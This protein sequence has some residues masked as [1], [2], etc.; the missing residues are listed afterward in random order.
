MP[1]SLHLLLLVSSIFLTG[2]CG[3]V[4]G[5]PEI[6]PNQDELIL[7]AGE[8]L[9]LTCRAAHPVAWCT[10]HKFTTEHYEELYDKTD[11]KAFIS[12][13][14]IDA[15]NT[16]HVGYFSC[17]FNTSENR[18]NNNCDVNDPAITSLYLYVKD[19]ENL[20]VTFQNG[21]VLHTP[22]RESVVLPCRSTFPQVNMTLTKNYEPYQRTEYDP[23]SGF[24]IKQ[25]TVKKNEGHYVCNAAYHHK[26]QERILIMDVTDLTKKPNQPTV[27]VE[28]AW[29]ED[30]LEDTVV[31]YVREG[32]SVNL[33]CIYQFKEV[34][35]SM[36]LEWSDSSSNKSGTHR[37]I[38]QVSNVSQ[39]KGRYYEINNATL[40]DS[41][42]YSCQAKNHQRYSD[43]SRLNISVVATDA[44]YLT[45]TIFDRNVTELVEENHPVQWEILFI[46]HPE[47]VFQ[48]KK[49]GKLLLD[50][51]MKTSREQFRNYEMKVTVEEA[52]LSLFLHHPTLADNGKY[53]LEAFLPNTNI[54]TTT[55]MFLMIP[56][57]PQN[58]QIKSPNDRQMFKEGENFSLTCSAE[59]YPKPNLTLHFVPENDTNLAHTKDGREYNQLKKGRGM[60]E[61]DHN[62]MVKRSVHW[63][64]VAEE[65][66]W[67]QCRAENDLGQDYSSRKL[68]Q[69]TDGESMLPISLRLEIGGE[70]KGVVGKTVT[71]VEGDDFKLT[72]RANK[73]SAKA[74][75]T[76]ALNDIPL[77]QATMK[78]WGMTVNESKTRLSLVS[79]VRATSLHRNADKFSIKCADLAHNHTDLIISVQEMVEPAWIGKPPGRDY[80]KNKNDKLTLSCPADGTPRPKVTWKKEGEPVEENNRRKIRNHDQLFFE[81]LSSSDA[82]KYTC[83]ISNRAGNL[84]ASFNVTVRDPDDEKTVL[85]LAIV[86]VLIVA[87]VVMSVFLCRKI[88]QARK[89]TLNLQLRE[90]RMFIEG[91]PSSLNPDIPLEQQAE[92][93]PYNTKYEV[94]RD[95]II[96]D[97]LL[98]TGAFGRVYRA[99]ALNLRPGETHTTVAVKMMKSRTDCSQLKA[100]RSEV[101]IMIHIGR[102]ANI[103]NLLGACSKDLASKGELLLLVEYCKHGNILDY[104]RRHRRDFVNQINTEDKI[105]PN[106]RE[107]RPRHRSDS[108]SRSHTSHGLKYTHLNFHQDNVFY[109]TTQTSDGPPATS[110]NLLSPCNTDGDA[111]CRPFRARTVSASS[112]SHH[113]ASDNSFL[114]CETSSGTSDGYLSAQSLNGTHV[115]C[116]TNL[117]EW[118]YQIAKGMEYLAFKKVL[119]GDLAARNVLLNE[120]NVVK[121]SDFGLAKDIYKNNN[122][123]KVTNGPVP[124]KWLAVECLRDGVFSTQSDVW[125]FG[126]VLW[127]IFSLGQIPYSCSEFDESFI[128]KLEKGVRLEQ[129]RYA[130]YGLYRL[131]L[132]CWNTDPMER[133]SFTTLEASLGDML[134]EV[135][136]QNYLQLNEPYEENATSEFLDLLAS[137]DYSAKMRQTTPLPTEDGYETPFS[138]GVAPYL[139]V[140][141]DRLST[142]T[143]LTNRQ[144]E[145]FRSAE[146]EDSASS[147]VP[148]SADRTDT[149]T[150]FDFDDKTVACFMSR[151]EKEEYG[152]QDLYLKMDKHSPEPDTPD[153]MHERR[154]CSPRRTVLKSVSSQG[155]QNGRHRQL[156]KHDSGVYSPTVLAHTNPEY[157]VMSTLLSTDDHNYIDT[158]ASEANSRVYA[159]LG[160]GNS[161]KARQYI[162]DSKCIAEYANLIP[163]DSGC[164]RAES[165]SSSGVDSVE[166]SSLPRGTEIEKFNVPPIP[167]EAMVV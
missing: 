45:T 40:Q 99:T 29:Q 35:L 48:W 76:W 165:D 150:V 9:N 51:R 88:Y 37:I 89:E 140:Q 92:L 6:F 113:V 31:Y 81:I 114:P 10:D 11:N 3:T 49:Q 167:E 78:K 164:D 101:K 79:T 42:I 109:G 128:L 41:G 160:T 90:Q 124:V 5:K 144:K 123:K 73:V 8:S 32:T 66:G 117:L 97:K 38:R 18:E 69:V 59:G 126:V 115:L 96:F 27:D 44:T 26:T 58:V 36:K 116:S 93:L 135:Q 157:L 57:K 54:T 134:G 149:N 62:D 22:V 154:Q 75:L 13:L 23:R 118:A 39:Y 142:P 107:P 121:I 136:R 33:T 119:H 53:T 110:T 21:I 70:V 108:S 162:G 47:P 63:I 152:N 91:D 147:Y 139:T 148:M 24:L 25:V 100:L 77:D 129:P 161:V 86:G 151:P 56:G 103:V 143:R 122:Y 94:S 132:E 85:I 20:M 28:G 112:S 34:P 146:G 127:E 155:S 131:M 71:V 133:P 84:S 72:C 111:G 145:Y 7:E 104:M 158:E 105:D 138:P 2:A 166:E 87:L 15:V 141:G 19:L 68:F 17:V 52:S 60:G 82:G 65:P 46:A 67:Y 125:S 12:T 80:D 16:S 156:T 1:P 130:T 95:S 102:H 43:P 159:N 14:T 74:P 83:E 153:G 106:F 64:G 4:L 50:S 98:G 61:D 137:Q 120:N 163:Q 30:G 55:T